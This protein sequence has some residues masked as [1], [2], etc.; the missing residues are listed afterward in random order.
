MLADGAVTGAIVETAGQRRAIRARRGVLLV[1]GGFEANEEL[2][3]AYG[4][5][6]VVRDTMGGPGSR[7]LALLA[8]IAA[9]ADTDLLDQAWWSPGMAHPDGRC[10]F[11]LW[12]TGGIFVNQHG[13][14]FV[15][16]S[17]AYDRVGREIIAQLQDGSMS[18]PY[19][20]IYDDS[21]GEVPPVKAANVSIVETEKYV[22]AGLWHTADT[23]EELAAKIGVPGD[24]LA[25]TVARFNDFAAAGVDV[26]FGR[27][28]EAFDRA[29]SAGASPLVPI[30]TPPYTPRSSGFRIWAPRAACAPTR[31]RASST[32]P[33][34]PIPGCTP[35]ATRWPPPAG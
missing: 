32:P 34:T 30:A 12:F 24:R 18:L 1:A 27:G 25:A 29:F 23:L 2:R 13:N 33:A 14:R 15:N 9:G 21:E 28:E 3:R 6:G 7:G 10:A 17:R 26:D 11:A 35:R 31:P 20:M 8:G 16:E 19:W 4:V 22:A 5:P